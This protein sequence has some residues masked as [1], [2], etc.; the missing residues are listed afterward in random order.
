V[1]GATVAQ[2]GADSIKA[3]LGF[4]TVMLMVFAG[5]ALFVGSFI[6]WNTFAM[7]VTQRSREIALLRAI[8]STRRQVMRSL[9]VEALLLGAGA[10]AIGLGLGVAVAKGLTALMGAVGMSLPTTSLQLEPRTIWVSLVVGTVVTVVAAVSPARKATKVLPVEALRDATPGAAAPSRRRAVV[11][12]VVIGLGLAS[13]FAG[14][15]GDGGGALLALGLVGH[16]LGVTTLAPLGARPLAALIGW[17]LRL[18]GVPATS[19]ARTRCATRVVRRRP[20]PR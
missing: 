13:L 9:L 8:G 14:L 5:I 7:I 2:E 19:L 1:T 12:V 18:R 17:P 16:L 10:S 4:F 20:L 11:G 3:N 15:F 6:I